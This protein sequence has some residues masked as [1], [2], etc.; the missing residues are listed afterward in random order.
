MAGRQVF[1]AERGSG[2]PSRG[3]MK[4][5]GHYVLPVRGTDC[6]GRRQAFRRSA[7]RVNGKRISILQ[8]LIDRPR[9]TRGL[10][11]SSKVTDCRG[12][13]LKRGRKCAA[14]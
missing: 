2:A 9:G 10:K 8:G 6:I 12:V 1:G 4:L 5:L 3:P 13:R 7:E 14:F 11:R